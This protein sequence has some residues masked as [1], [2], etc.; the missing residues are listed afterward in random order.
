MTK[1]ISTNPNVLFRE[2]CRSQAHKASDN[3]K[4]SKCTQKMHRYVYMQPLELICISSVQ[5]PQRAYNAG[6]AAA[7]NVKTTNIMHVGA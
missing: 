3:D 2:H 6:Q 1:S 7:M 4:P 5:N